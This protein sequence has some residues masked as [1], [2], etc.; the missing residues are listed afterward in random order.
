MSKPR[1]REP[2]TC[3]ELME[4]AFIRARLTTEPARRALARVSPLLANV[5]KAEH[6][7]APATSESFLAASS[8]FPRQE[9]I[10]LSISPVPEGG[11]RL[12]MP[13]SRYLIRAEPIKMV[14]I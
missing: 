1:S 6:F 2:R 3:L 9:F 5:A 8:P 13:A 11:R 10:K 4:P 12:L 14:T 7:H